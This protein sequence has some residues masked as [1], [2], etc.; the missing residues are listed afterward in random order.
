MNITIQTPQFTASERLNNFVKEKIN[1]LSNHQ[2]NIIGVKVVL[3]TGAKHDISNQWCEIVVTLPAEN[4][5]IKK[6]SLSFEESITRAVSSMERKLKR[7]Q[8]QYIY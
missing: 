4:K 1:Q 3:R 5:F 8:E 2:S 6:H 7:K